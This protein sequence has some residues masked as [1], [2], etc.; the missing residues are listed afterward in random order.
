LPALLGALLAALLVR[1]FIGGVYRIESNSMEPTLHAQGE[2]VFV[3]YGRGWVPERFG[4]IVFTP[5]TESA[6]VVKRVAGLPGESL[7]I[8][9]G[10][11]LIEGERL[12]AYVP[13]PEP[14]PVFDSRLEPLEQ[15]FAPPEMPLVPRQAG[16]SLDARGRSVELL[17]SRRATDDHFDAKG[18]RVEGQREVNDLRL[19]GRFG[20]KGSGT[21]LLRLTEEGDLFELELSIESDRLARARLL[22]R[23]G[24]AAAPRVLTESD[25]P[26][27]DRLSAADFELA[28]ENVDNHLV[29][30]VAG[31]VIGASYPANT[32]LTGVLD[33]SYRHL[34]PRAALVVAGMEL[35]LRWLCVARDLYYTSAGTRGTGSAIALGRDELFL[36]GDNSSDSRDSRTIGPVALDAVAGRPLSVVWPLGAMRRLGG[37][38][39]LPQA[40]AAR[41]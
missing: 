31:R 30:V 34:K 4:L 24:L 33:E 25:W 38:R 2:R 28:F 21:L 41:Q 1:T 9:G 10:D 20:L 27:Q 40:Q 8:S 12:A 3:R 11:L 26:G 16:W 5:A 36:L 18:R 39:V 7:L 15:A 13:R 37:L 35:D 14:I 23:E 32:P 17:Y 29:A 22:R 19:E 6:A